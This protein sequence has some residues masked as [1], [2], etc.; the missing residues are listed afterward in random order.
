MEIKSLNI[1]GAYLAQNEVFEDERGYFSEWYSKRILESSRIEFETRQANIST[2]KK[3]VFR[4]IHFSIDP[5]G[6]SKFVTCANGT[7]VDYIVDLRNDSPTYLQSETI[8]LTEGQ[9][10]S[11]HIP[12][13]VGHGFLVSSERATVVYLSSTTY[14]PEFE[15][16]IN[17]FDP[18]LGL[19]FGEVG[20]S[21]IIRSP[22]DMTAVDFADLNLKGE[23]HN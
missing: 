14:K 15:I 17:A 12:P 9:G 10:C 6:Q 5:E 20:R 2:S 13:G 4:G 22:R 18:T 19:D 8:F 16:T 3:N 11:V 21:R 23:S 7:I 1:D